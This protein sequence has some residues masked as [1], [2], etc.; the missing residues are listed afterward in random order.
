MEATD[1]VKAFLGVKLLELDGEFVSIVARDNLRVQLNGL[2][3]E[4]LCQNGDVVSEP[5]LEAER[6]NV[7]VGSQHDYELILGADWAVC[8]ADRHED[9]VGLLFYELQQAMEVFHEVSEARHGH[10]EHQDFVIGR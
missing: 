1:Q 4:F 7:L 6:L 3:D 10:I 2:G 8:K 5:A 9:F